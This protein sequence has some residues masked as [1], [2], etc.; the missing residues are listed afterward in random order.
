MP[1]LLATTIAIALTLFVER[2]SFKGRLIAASPIPPFARIFRQ[3]KLHMF[4]LFF[5]L[6]MSNFVDKIK[7]TTINACL[8]R[9]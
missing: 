4:L 6:S 2:I 7:G 9:L 8:D 1:K 3:E 5:H